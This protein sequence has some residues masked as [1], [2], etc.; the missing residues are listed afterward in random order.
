VY[1]SLIFARLL[2]SYHELVRRNYLKDFDGI[3]QLELEEHLTESEFLV[4]FNMTK[5]HPPLAVSLTLPSSLP[6][7]AVQRASEVAPHREEKEL[8]A[9]LIIF[10]L[11][12][13]S[14]PESRK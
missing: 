10:S 6:P 2:F 7:G 5:V 1:L 3:V 4:R 11:L 9:L 13:Y 12:L 8:D 14:P